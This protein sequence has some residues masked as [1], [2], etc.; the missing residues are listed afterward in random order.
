MTATPTPLE[1]TRRSLHA[2]AEHVL[3]AALHTATGRIGLRAAPGGLTT[4][5]FPGPDGPRRVGVDGLDLVVSDDGHER[6]SPLTTVGA[7][8]ALVGIR[9]GAPADVY[10]PSTPL[11]PDRPLD[12]DLVS[13]RRLAAF[14]AATDDALARLATAAPTA[15]PS[16]P[17]AVAQLWPEHLDLALT[18]DEVNYGGSPGDDEHPLPYLYV[19]PWTPPTD[20]DPFWNEPFGASTTVSSDLDPTTALAFFTDGRRRLHR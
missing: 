20:S 19:G 13:A 14:F 9:P 11:E 5:A 10:T 18:I 7:A 17:P 16:A 8:A 1:R 6:R 3:G 2:V 4:P 12:L 15:D